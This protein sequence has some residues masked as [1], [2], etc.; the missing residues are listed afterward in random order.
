MSGTRYTFRSNRL[1]GRHGWL[2]LTPA[3]SVH[4]VEEM[5]ESRGDPGLVLDPFCGTGTTALVCA[6][7]G[8]PSVTV[9]INPFLVWLANTKTDEYGEADLREAEAWALSW[10][11]MA[12]DYW[13]PPIA[14]IDRW[15]NGETRRELGALR[16]DICDASVSERS[17]NLLLVAFCRT[18]IEASRVSFGHQSLSFQHDISH[19]HNKTTTHQ[20]IGPPFRKFLN[21]I[22]E[23]AASHRIVVRPIIQP[24]DA[25]DL[26]GLLGDFAPI[27]T[28][29]TSPPYPN[30][31]SYVRELRPYL[32]WLGFLESGSEAGELDWRAIG[33]TWGAATSRLTRWEPPVDLPSELSFV[34]TAVAAIATRSPVLARYVER[35]V[36]DMRTHVRSVVRLLSPGANLAYV[37]GNS[38][39]YDVMVETERITGA[40]LA[41]A[42]MTEISIRPIRKRTSK[43]ELF[44]FIVEGRLAH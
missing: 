19:E 30:R 38:R 32:Y 18:M 5:L 7:K 6:S 17:R 37:V 21:G 1:Q 8:I 26:A 9:D 10:R 34:T 3:Y 25:R 36:H 13:L 28:V 40:I 12:G 39:F 24:G 11:P 2:R 14:N 27:Q 44:E 23:T 43:R 41:E 15:W 29:V 22:S 31:M 42:G 35:Y 16:Q 4:V 20:T 33:G